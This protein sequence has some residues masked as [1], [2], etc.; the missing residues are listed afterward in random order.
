MPVH[1]AKS[2]WCN[3]VLRIVLALS[4]LTVTGCILAVP[5]MKKQEQKREARE[6]KMWDLQEEQRQQQKQK[7]A[8]KP[9]PAQ[10]QPLKPS[11]F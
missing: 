7:Q 1:P 6:E 9:K 2:L 10:Q 3:L 5:A 11:D 8:P 4:V